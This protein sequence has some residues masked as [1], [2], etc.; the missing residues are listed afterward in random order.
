MGGETREKGEIAFTVTLGTCTFLDKW[1]I[2]FIFCYPICKLI[3][4][5]WGK[6]QRRIPRARGFAE[7]L[8]WH[9]RLA[10]QAAHSFGLPTLTSE[11]W[12]GS[13]GKPQLS[14]LLGWQGIGTIS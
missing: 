2:V 7:P 11:R 8:V 9:C 12:C 10:T 14:C 3:L 13:Q 5:D 4:E 1:L 6:A